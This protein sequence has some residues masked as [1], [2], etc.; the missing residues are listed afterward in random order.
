VPFFLETGVIEPDSLDGTDDVAALEELAGEGA[1]IVT[2]EDL[3]SVAL[4][5]RADAVVEP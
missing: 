2:T 3:R 1:V 4:P 5:S